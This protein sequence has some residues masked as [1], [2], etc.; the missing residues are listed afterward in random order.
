M[1]LW[2]LLAR[3]CCKEGHWQTVKRGV[4]RIDVF[5]R[6]RHRDETPGLKLHRKSVMGGFQSLFFLP[7]LILIGI[8]LGLQWQND[9][10]VTSSTLPFG[11][12]DQVQVT[13]GRFL[14]SA[15]FWGY[16]G[17]DCCSNIEVSASGISRANETLTCIPWE[18]GCNVTW[19]SGA[20]AEV[21]GTTAVRLTLQDGE[22]FQY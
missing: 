3:A 2:V 7:V 6:S 13:S 4:S 11:Y 16:A 14:A 21:G 22:E 1:L 9:S 20:N 12:L 18:Y 17:E 8:A 10:I 5:F 15:A 19:D